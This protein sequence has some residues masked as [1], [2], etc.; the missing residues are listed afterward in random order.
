V[1][2]PYRV[3]RMVLPGV[4]RQHLRPDGRGGVKHDLPGW[5]LGR[6]IHIA[7]VRLRSGQHL[8]L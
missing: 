4:A 6:A 5:R 2:Q 1:A 7:S 8:Q 3:V